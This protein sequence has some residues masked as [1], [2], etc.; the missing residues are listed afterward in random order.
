MIS[1]LPLRISYRSAQ[2]DVLEDFSRPCLDQAVGY[3]TSAGLAHAAKGLVSLVVRGAKMRLVASP[4]LSDDDI[5]ALSRA[6]DEPARVLG[7]IVAQSLQDVINSL[8]RVRLNALAWLAARGALEVKLAIRLNKDGQLAL[9][10]YHE[11]IGIFTDAA[12][13]LSHSRVRPVKPGVERWRFSK[14]S[15]CFR[16]GKMLKTVS[17]KRS[18]TS[19]HSGRTKRVDFEFWT[20]P[21]PR[22]NCSRVT[23]KTRLQTP[24][25][26]S[27]DWVVTPPD[28]GQFPSQQLSHSR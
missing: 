17:K 14:A 18:K 13:I 28:C 25:A 27:A 9:G 26:C 22:V 15:R 5:E 7:D 2:D 10:V 21:R 20:S 23:N 6:A 1:S 11:K 16:L 12:A 19:T 3:T 4:Q 24:R 8:V